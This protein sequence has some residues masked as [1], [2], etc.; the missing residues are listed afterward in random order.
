MSKHKRIAAPGTLTAIAIMSLRDNACPPPPSSLTGAAAVTCPVL[1]LAGAA[2][3]ALNK[4]V[5]NAVELPV[6]EEVEAEAAAADEADA[7]LLAADGRLELLMGV[8]LFMVIDVL[9]RLRLLRVELLVG[10]LVR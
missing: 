2:L 8:A 9:A 3:L 6:E 10:L 4:L 5:I 1:L 7:P